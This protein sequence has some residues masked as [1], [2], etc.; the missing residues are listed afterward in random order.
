MEHRNTSQNIA[1]ISNM[2][3]YLE[4]CKY[5]EDEFLHWKIG[6][7]YAV[8]VSLAERLVE[9]DGQLL[10]RQEKSIIFEQQ[11]T[12]AKP[13]VKSMGPPKPAVL[14]HSGFFWMVVSKYGGFP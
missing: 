6:L 12:L 1:R 4:P 10:G 7:P 8:A 3:P 13:P 11:I 2:E 5:I 9:I 14:S